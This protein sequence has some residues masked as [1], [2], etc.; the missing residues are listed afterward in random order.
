METKGKE[1]GGGYQLCLNSQS[2]LS[3][4][5]IVSHIFLHLI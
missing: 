3:T 4:N 2:F 5:K 1:R